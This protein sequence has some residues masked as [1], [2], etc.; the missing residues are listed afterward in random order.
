MSRICKAHSVAAQISVFI[1]VFKFLRRG[2]RIKIKR[3]YLFA[4]T[5]TGSPTP[6]LPPHPL[7]AKI[8]KASVCPTEGRKTKSEIKEVASMAAL[9]GGW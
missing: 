9:A 6:P 5:G 2:A 3:T 1:A 8:V 4:V 7:L